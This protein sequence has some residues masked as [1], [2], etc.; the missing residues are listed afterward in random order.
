MS[1]C[2]QSSCWCAPIRWMG[3]CKPKR[4]SPVTEVAVNTINNL[5]HHRTRTWQIS[6]DGKMRYEPSKSV[7]RI[8]VHE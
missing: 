6:T 1:N 5:Q 3:C 8:E 7:V 4:A 2:I